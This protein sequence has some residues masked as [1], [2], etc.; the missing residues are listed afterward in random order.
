RNVEAPGVQRRAA[1]GA[2]DDVQLCVLRG[3]ITER[4]YVAA[5]SYLYLTPAL[6]AKERH[7]NIRNLKSG[8]VR[9]VFRMPDQLLAFLHAFLQRSRIGMHVEDGGL[10]ERHKLR[11][12]APAW[13]GVCRKGGATRKGYQRRTA[14]HVD[15]H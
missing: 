14:G 8:F 2:N 13:L 10:V 5:K 9:L 4:G 3:A 15:S 11:V 1:F 6:L 7:G 12:L